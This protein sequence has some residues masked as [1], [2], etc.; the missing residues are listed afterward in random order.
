MKKVGRTKRKVD[1]NKSS[2]FCDSHKGAKEKILH[3]YKRFEIKEE[4]N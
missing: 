3:T 2:V 1:C 4:P